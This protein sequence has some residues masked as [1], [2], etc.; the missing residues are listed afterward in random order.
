MHAGCASTYTT[1]CVCPFCHQLLG[2]R[3]FSAE[4]GLRVDACTGGACIHACAYRQPGWE[5]SQDCA[6]QEDRGEVGEIALLNPPHLQLL[7]AV[8]NQQLADMPP[9]KWL[10]CISCKLQSNCVMSA[11]TCLRRCVYLDTLHH[12]ELHMHQEGMPLRR[13]K[14]ARQCGAQASGTKYC[15]QPTGRRRTCMMVCAG[16]AGH[17]WT[18]A[19]EPKHAQEPLR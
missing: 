13:N 19:C 14:G 11:L 8:Q 4:V 12:S 18:Q 6:H 15:K 2:L 3:S 5:G 9:A 7:T 1:E 17:T 10:P 16:S